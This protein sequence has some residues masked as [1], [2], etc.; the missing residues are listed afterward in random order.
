MYR[1][2]VSNRGLGSVKGWLDEDDPFFK[3]LDEII[4][5]RQILKVRD[6]DLDVE[7]PSPIV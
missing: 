6:D 3:D 7:C 4:Q 2:D 1:E 5:K